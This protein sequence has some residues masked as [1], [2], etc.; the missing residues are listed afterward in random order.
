MVWATRLAYGT[1]QIP[2]K[3]ICACHER[4]ESYGNFSCQVRAKHL[5]HAERSSAHHSPFSGS[6]RT[7]SRKPRSASLGS[8]PS[9]IPGTQHMKGHVLAWP[10]KCLCSY[11]KRACK[12]KHFTW[13]T[14]YVSKQ[15][16]LQAWHSYERTLGVV[17][18][19]LDVHILLLDFLVGV[20]EA[21]VCP[22]TGRL[23]GAHANEHYRSHLL[24]LRL[25]SNKRLLRH[26]FHS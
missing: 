20:L 2:L 21:I 19:V 5:Y 17:V 7:T 24:S 18:L 25:Q 9:S 1:P 4:S 26:T 3:K 23:L 14:A 22:S 10:S 13:Q 12:A 15:S 6:I 8:L 11:C 16:S